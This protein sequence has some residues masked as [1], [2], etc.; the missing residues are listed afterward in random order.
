MG[1]KRIS[2]KRKFCCLRSWVYRLLATGIVV[3]LWLQLTPGNLSHGL[4]GV[5]RV[6][7]RCIYYVALTDKDT[8]WLSADKG[9]VTTFSG[10]SLVA[11]TSFNSGFVVSGSGAVV[12]SAS[13]ISFAG[14]EICSDSLAKILTKE[15]DRL[16]IL[17]ENKREAARELDYYARTHSVVDDGYN[18]VMAYRVRNTRE[19][20]HVE[21]Q[22]ELIGLSLI[23]I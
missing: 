16:E 20:I 19:R 6:M 13:A 2:M 17:R 15:K 21:R 23:H 3:A 9:M 4:N 7:T 12:T 14:D 1:L 11:D 8:L 18:E 10:D 5:C 22:L